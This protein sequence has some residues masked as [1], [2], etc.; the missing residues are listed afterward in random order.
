MH[1]YPSVY[2]DK[3]GKNWIAD[4]LGGTREHPSGLYGREGFATFGAAVEAADNYARAER[5][6]YHSALRASY[7][8]ER[9]T[10]VHRRAEGNRDRRLLAGAVSRLLTVPA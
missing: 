6:Q 4:Y 5:A 2:R 3:F 8:F 7:A 9:A 10:E 1:G